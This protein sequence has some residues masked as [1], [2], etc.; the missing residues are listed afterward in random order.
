M[1]KGLAL[2]YDGT[3]RVKHIIKRLMINI[4]Q[5]QEN[6]KWFVFP[7]EETSISEGKKR[8][9]TEWGYSFKVLSNGII[10]VYFEEGYNTPVDAIIAMIKIVD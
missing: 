5:A 10:W 8:K 1:L 7:V 9:Y 4:R 2:N 3:N 6:L